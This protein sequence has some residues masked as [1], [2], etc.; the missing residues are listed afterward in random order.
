MQAA[1]E[2]PRFRQDLVAEPIEDQ[3]GTFIDVMDPDSGNVFRFYEVEFSIACAMD[4][5]RDAAGIVQWAKEEL[6]LTPSLGEVRSVIATLGELGYLAPV[7]QASAARE[8]AAG[9]SKAAS[10]ELAPGIVVGTPARKPDAIDVELGSAGTPPQAAGAALAK[11]P[12]FDL[13]APGAPVAAKPSRAAAEDVALGAPGRV[14]DA[15]SKADVSL[16]LAD[17]AP[18]RADDVKEAVR[19]SKVMA[20]VELPKELVAAEVPV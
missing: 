16:D 2:R 3:G 15:S 5:E 9:A 8:A 10:R 13:G 12:D 4:G 17:H 14:A 1:F 20:A 6:G 11:A 7:D 18:V 19:Q